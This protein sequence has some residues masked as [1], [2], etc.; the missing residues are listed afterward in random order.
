MATIGPHLKALC[1][2]K[3]ANQ[4][5]LFNFPEMEKGNMTEQQSMNIV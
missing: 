1:I 4:C 2:Q 3:P 5:V